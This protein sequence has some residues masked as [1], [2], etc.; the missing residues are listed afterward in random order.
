MLDPKKAIGTKVPDTEN[1]FR[2][3]DA[4]VYALGIGF[5]QDPLKRE[6]YKF[7]YENDGDFQVFPTLPVL[8][9]GNPLE[10]MG[11]DGI[12]DFNPM[13]LLHA[14][15]HCEFL[16]PIEVNSKLRTESDIFDVAD[17]GKFGII[18]MR[19][20]VHNEANEHVATVYRS[21]LIKGIGGFGHKGKGGFKLPAIPT[22]KPEQFFETKTEPNQAFLYRLSLDTNP[23]H[24]DP[25]M[26]AMGGFDQPIL[27]GLCTYGF[28]V[29][30]VYEK[31]CN[32]DASLIAKTGVRFTSHVFPGQTLIVEMWKKGNTIVF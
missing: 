17:K 26:A 18:T 3:N 24:V 29:R 27:H 14:E 6:D 5:N 4:I 10:L 19:G 23:L 7:T 2:T 9:S 8:L 31:Y 28:S 32:G 22:E 1:H 15:D 11:K 21:L 12:P 30:A 13:K 20:K 16:K 25:D